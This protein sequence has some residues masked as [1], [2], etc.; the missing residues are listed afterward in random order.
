[1]KRL[2][3]IILAIFLLAFAAQAQQSEGTASIQVSG[4]TVHE[5]LSKIVVYQPIEGT[6]AVEIWIN[7][8]G[9]VQSAYAGANG[10]TITHKDLL[11]AARAAAMKLHFNTSINAPVLQP[12][13]ITYKFILSESEPHLKTNVIQHQDGILKQ[14]EDDFKFLSIPVDGTKEAMIASLKQ[15]SFVPEWGDEYLTGIFNGEK[16]KLYIG[17]N[18]GIVDRITIEYPPYV[19]DDIRVKYN[20]LLSR[21]NRNS[22]YVCVFQRP[23][24]SQNQNIYEYSKHS[25][26]VYFF[27]RSNVDKNTWVQTF[28]TEYQKR[29]K[30]PLVSLSYDEMEE[31]LFCLPAKVSKAVSGIVWFTL[32]PFYFTYKI[33]INYVN[34]NNRPHGEDL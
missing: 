2:K 29:Y 12:G 33:S 14:K 24:I 16:V 19:D 26:A 8:Y 10:T 4:R 31:V 23:E 3:L 22:K 9:I 30:K 17:T 32:D 13:L 1:M 25:D 6:I 18:H 7:Q 5:G 11:N 34:L 15:K 20:T 21:F 28:K 27:L